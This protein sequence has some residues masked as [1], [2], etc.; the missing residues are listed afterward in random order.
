[1]I[2]FVIKFNF[3]NPFIAMKKI[4]L[5]SV[6]FFFPLF[7]FAQVSGNQVYNNYSRHTY[8]SGKNTPEQLA[9]SD[10]TFL[11]Q[12]NILKKVKA[13]YYVA[14]FGVTQVGKTP[15]ECNKKMNN[16]I[17]SFLKGLDKLDVNPEYIYV[18]M[19]AQVP[20]YEYEKKIS[21]AEEHFIGFE[22]KKNV[23][24]R[25]DNIALLEEFM[26]IAAKDSIYDLIKVDY[27]IKNRQKV[28]DELFDEAVKIINKKKQKYVQLTNARLHPQS[29]IY[30]ENFITY[31]PS[32][33]YDDYKAYSGNQY[34]QRWKSTTDKL[35]AR[36]LAT[37]YYNG[38]EFSGFDK[39]LNAGIIEP[40][41]EFVMTL[42]VKFK[43][44]NN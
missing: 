5:L 39:I 7:I 43:M 44:L 21:V 12:A 25:F 35:S 17:E 32:E 19:V 31:T 33:L 6:Y 10:S 27:R 26:K 2:I 28:Y 34:T 30:A 22:L 42:E 29:Q 3:F 14:V 36:K 41:L 38:L 18:D 15:E 23:I 40:C 13:D 24:I 1:M 9:L 37:F 16:K 4:F 11:I 20:L 8:F